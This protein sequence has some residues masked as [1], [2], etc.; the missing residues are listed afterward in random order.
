SRPPAARWPGI[1]PQREANRP[2]AWRQSEAFHPA[3]SDPSEASPKSRFCSPRL[4]L[5]QIEEGNDLTPPFDTD[6]LLPVITTDADS[7]KVLMMG[8][9]TRSIETGR[10]HCWSRSRQCLCHGR[11]TS[12]LVQHIV[13]TR[14]DDDQDADWLA[15]QPME[16]PT[17]M[18]AIG[19]A[20]I[21]AGQWVAPACWPSPKA[22]RS[23]MAMLR[24]HAARRWMERALPLARRRIWPPLRSAASLSMTKRGRQR[25]RPSL[26]VGSIT[27]RGRTHGRA[28]N[29]TVYVMLESCRN[30]GRTLPCAEAIIAT[31]MARVVVAMM[32]AP[33]PRMSGNGLARLR[34]VSI[35][36]DIVEAAEAARGIIAGLLQRVTAGRFQG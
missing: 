6:G 1:R 28:R 14:I 33:Y 17:A 35:A 8:A 22:R 11:T 36:V 19:R 30:W 15:A 13:E 25:P 4:N 32:Q 16:A 21:A 34:K 24:P 26:A 5:D 7:G 29:C 20:S 31:G 27:R 23:S 12:G 18:S 9:V 3:S 10:T 2:F